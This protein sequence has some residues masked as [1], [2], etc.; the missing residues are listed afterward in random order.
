MMSR[1]PIRVALTTPFTTSGCFSM[2]S[3]EAR[4]AWAMLAKTSFCGS[5]LTDCPASSAFTTQSGTAAIAWDLP[6][7]NNCQT[8]EGPAACTS[9]S[10]LFRPALR[11]EASSA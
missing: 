1:M 2:A 11:I 10:F 3:S 4:M 6:A 9:M 8:P 7:E 5:S